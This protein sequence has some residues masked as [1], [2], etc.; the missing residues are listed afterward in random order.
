MNLSPMAYVRGAI[1]NAMLED[2]T[3]EELFAAAEYAETCEAFDN[4]VN[5]LAQTMP[6][7]QQET[8]E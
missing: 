4:A 7:K 8:G 5:E 1:V 2:M 3:L 6:A